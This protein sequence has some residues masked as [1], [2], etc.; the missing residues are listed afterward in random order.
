M[1]LLTDDKKISKA[2]FLLMFVA[3]SLLAET[4]ADLLEIFIFLEIIMEI[5]RQSISHF[6]SYISI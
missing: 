3:I 5:F 6:K 1:A 2:G 4:I